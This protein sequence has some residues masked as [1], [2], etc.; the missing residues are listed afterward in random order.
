MMKKIRI[1][2][3]A[4]VAVLFAFSPAFSAKA[5]D[6]DRIRNYDIS[7][8]VND[9]ATL[10]IAYN[11][12]WHVMETCDEPLEWV[13]I[14]IPNNRT[15]SYKAT[16]DNIKSIKTK[17]SNGSHVVIYF[18]KK[19]KAG[20]TIN[21]GFEIVQ[22][23]MYEMNKYEEGLSVFEFTPG[24]FEEIF[25][26]RISV[27]WDA[28]KAEAWSPSAI[29]DNGKI[30]WTS[31]LGKN[32][33]MTVSVTYPNSA[34][35]FDSTKKIEGYSEPTAFESFLEVIAGIGI[36][37]VI[38]IVMIVIPAALV[39][40]VSYK[41][42]SGLGTSYDKKIT[43]TKVTFY[44][45]CPGC[46]AVREEGRETC[47]Y[48]GRSMIES[49]E[50]IEETEIPKEDKGK[51]DNDG[52]FSY[53]SVPNTYVRVHVTKVPRPVSTTRSTYH[54]SCAHSSCACACACACAGGGR[55]GCSAKDFYNTNL[56]LRDLMLRKKY[57]KQK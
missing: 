43:R 29:L 33:K 48:C 55:A 51:F 22:D 31:S 12:E 1:F 53:H 40:L 46:G 57:G 28:D 36:L 10:N 11:I 42:G 37:A 35:L 54:S 3:F 14:G 2:V 47:T 6:L 34:F 20:E 15:V 5:A 39:S 49:E 44:A 56:K 8:S 27:T 26:E 25:V 21:F 38:V 17:S 24:W 45:N 7:V 41:K 32:E 52:L 23:Y 4:L 13:E 18:D 19:V 30:V 9:D 16:T 50:K